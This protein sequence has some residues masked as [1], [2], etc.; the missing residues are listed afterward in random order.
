MLL[1]D[2]KKLIRG[3]EIQIDAIA[4]EVLRND[5]R[6]GAKDA[7]N[8]ALSQSGLA[9]PAFMCT[10]ENTANSV[11]FYVEKVKNRKQQS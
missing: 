2:Y 4:N 3:K 9:H 11:L 6:I 8:S 7:L 5:W 10:N 1:K